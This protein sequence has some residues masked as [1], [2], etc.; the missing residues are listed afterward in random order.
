M[1]STVTTGQVTPEALKGTIQGGDAPQ[2]VDVRTAEAYERWHIPGAIHLLYNADRDAFDRNPTDV[3]PA[4]ERVIVVCAH[5]NTSRLAAKALARRGFDVSHL[6]GGMLGWSQVFDVVDVDLRPDLVFKQVKRVASG[7]LS[8]VLGANG[9]AMI[10]DPV[11]YTDVYDRNLRF[12]ERFGTEDGALPDV[13]YVALTHVHADHVSSA[14]D[15]A[16]TYD[17]EFV[18]GAAV[19][20]RTTTP[21][22]TPDYRPVADGET[23]DLGGCAIEVLHTPGHTMES[24]SY[25][26]GEEAVLTGDAQF[27]DS[28][29]RPDLEHGDDGAAEH[30]SVLYD[31]IFETILS[32]DDD[33]IVYPAHWD[34][35][36]VALG[37]PI[38][39]TVG[40]IEATNPAVQ[41][42]SRSAFV[43]HV[44]E[45]LGSKPSN[46]DEIIAINEGRRTLEDEE[47]EL[48]PNNC[49][50]DTD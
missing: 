12:D 27:V 36:D 41:L 19:D 10:V 42:D 18:V 24:V 16:E 50:V 30:A 20:E 37:S 48:G 46:H 6:E 15:L 31:S 29:G 9:E 26:V 5:G 45:G 23:L 35:E 47:I 22:G 34:A 21:G 17:A 33:V 8:Y 32:L 13:T 28:V 3:L 4:D 2:I 38:S 11:Q 43:E 40:Q 14:A 44:L 49:A 25:R 7:C 1:S 39:A